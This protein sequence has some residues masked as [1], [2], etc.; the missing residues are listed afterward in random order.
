M[1]FKYGIRPFKSNIV[2]AT[3]TV[4]KVVTRDPFT[5]GLKDQ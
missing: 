1:T 4:K 3:Y 5:K 2:K